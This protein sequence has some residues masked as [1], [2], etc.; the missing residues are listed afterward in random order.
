MY[1]KIAPI[2][3]NAGKNASF[4]DVFVAQPD[5]LKESLAGKIFILAEINA[6]KNEGN[7]IF[8]FLIE[9]LDNYYYNDEKISLRDKIEGLRLENIFEAALAKVNKDLNEFL[10][11]EKIKIHIPSTSITIGVVFENK[12][13]FSSFGKNRALLIYRRNDQYEVINVE[14]NATDLKENKEE[15]EYSGAKELNLFSSVISGEIPINSFFFF[16]S[17]A[18]PEY[19]SNK[20]IIAIITKLPPIVAAEQIKNTLEKINTYVPFLGVLIKNT[21][22]LNLQETKEEFEEIVNP[23][24]KNSSLNHIEQKTEELLAPAGVINLSKILKSG[25]NIFGIW[26]LKKLATLKRSFKPEDN[27]DNAEP[28]IDLGRVKSLNLARSDSFLVK[29]KIFFKK[30][31]GEFFEKFKNVFQIIF[32]IFNPQNWL[33]L[34]LKFRDWF[35]AL[36]SKNSFLFSGLVILVVVFSLSIVLTNIG[37]KNKAANSSFDNLVAQIE[38]QKNSIDTYLLYSNEE[39]ARGALITAQSLINSLPREKNSQKLI[40]DQLNLKLNE[41]AA[42]VQKIV[43]IDQLEKTNDLTGLDLNS[44][45][46]AGGNI[47]ASD[48]S[49]IY[50]LTINSSSSTKSAI[51]G[52]V[53]ISNPYQS[54]NEKNYL[55]YLN[56]NQL[57]KFDIKK[58]TSS[59]IN[60]NNSDGAADLKT[61]K[62]YGGSLYVISKLNNQIYKYS[63]SASGFT[64][65]TSWLKEDFDLAQAADLS[66]VD[67]DIYLLKNTG[68]I[69]KFFQGKKQE[70]NAPALYP[71]MTSA[72]ELFVGVKY[73][74]LF[75]ASSKRLVVIN[76]KDGRLL[77]QYELS[78]LDNLRDFTVNEEAKQAYILTNNTIYRINL[79]Q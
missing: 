67:G 75:E 4:S 66:V 51:T 2:I 16:T 27:T 40:Y 43:K 18:L 72:N 31:P 25:K 30:K 12:L 60:I 10:I 37:L 26:P 56:S 29:D 32:Q 33:A 39:G 61:Y 15:K 11:A 70:Y 79:N 38:E 20:E 17:E 64:T 45:I 49:N 63:K 9:A 57:I 46:L 13:Y 54:F 34:I 35:K 55:Y 52:A 47:Y 44:I 65:K 23:Q 14:T 5:S 68:E 62:I 50:T 48:Q 78:T 58:K 74:Y 3:L 6:K 19:L 1:N 53:A 21:I 77:N 76:K 28:M 41:Q 69:I 36:N 59:L 42:K 7:L 8:N 24:P 73:I 22:G 71:A